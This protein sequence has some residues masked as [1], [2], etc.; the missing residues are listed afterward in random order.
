MRER[1]ILEAV[2]DPVTASEIHRVNRQ[3]SINRLDE[4]DGS[5]QN[6][7]AGGREDSFLLAV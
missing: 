7:S 2:S 6:Q 1:I 4:S 3:H 5:P